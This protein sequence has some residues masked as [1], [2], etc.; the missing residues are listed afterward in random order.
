MIHTYW[1]G[2]RQTFRKSYA[3]SNVLSCTNIKYSDT[4][5]NLAMGIFVK[6]TEY[7]TNPEDMWVFFT[8][9]HI[10][11]GIPYVLSAVVDRLVGGDGDGEELSGKLQHG[12]VLEDDG[13][14]PDSGPLY[15]QSVL[16]VRIIPGRH[17]H[18]FELIQYT[19]SSCLNDRGF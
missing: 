16:A 10:H 1:H 18:R 17:L 15:S 2:I 13:P 9:Y 12:L 3:P 14:A 5:T 7:H 19:N 4:Y 8:S 6:V 11:I